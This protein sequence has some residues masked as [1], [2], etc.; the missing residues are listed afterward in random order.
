MSFG[1]WYV[2]RG[3]IG[4]RT[5]W[6]QYF[7]PLFLLSLL[8][9]IADEVLGYPGLVAEPGDSGLYAWAGGPVELGLLIFLLAP[10][11]SSQV[12]R[13]HDRGQSAWWLLF[14]LVPVVG[15]LVLFVRMGFQRGDGGPNRY[16]PPEGSAVDPLG[17]GLDT[18]A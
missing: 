18:W 5:W 3:R 8:A 17:A 7:L 16:G 4:R 9:G 2:R 11:V 14:N 15:P 6:S 12:T 10:S 1:E 13:L